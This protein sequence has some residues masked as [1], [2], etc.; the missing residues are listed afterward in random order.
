MSKINFVLGDALSYNELNRLQELANDENRKHLLFNKYIRKG[1]LPSSTGSP[2]GF[3]LYAGSDTTRFYVSRGVAIT[4]DDRLILLREDIAVDKPSQARHIYIRY[5]EETAEEGTV[6]VDRGDT[7]VATME[8]VGT[9]FT[10]LLRQSQPG[11]P[12][13]VLLFEGEKNVEGR[14]FR[15]GSV[16]SD[17]LAT[18]L[19][20]VVGRDDDIRLSLPE[21]GKTFRYKVLPFTGIG[22]QRANSLPFY[23][24]DSVEIVQESTHVTETN[25]FKIG[26][27][28]GGTIRDSRIWSTASE[29]G[30]YFPGATTENGDADDTEVIEET[31]TP[32]V[33]D[34]IKV[35]P[36]ADMSRLSVSFDW[37]IKVTNVDVAVRSS[38]KG[39]L[40]IMDGSVVSSKVGNSTAAALY[41]LLDGRSHLYKAYIEDEPVSLQI[42]SVDATNNRIN[43]S[44]LGG[45]ELGT[46]KDLRIVP[47]V[48]KVG[49]V[50]TRRASGANTAVA[51]RGEFN[52]YEFNRNSTDIE[53]H[54]ATTFDIE[55]YYVSK[56]VRSTSVVNWA[57]SHPFGVFNSSNE[58]V[59]SNVTDAVRFTLFSSSTSVSSSVTGISINGNSGNKYTMVLNNT[60]AFTETGK[61]LTMRSNTTS[62]DII[63]LVA[64]TTLI[65][66]VDLDLSISKTDNNLA[67]KSG[68]TNLGDVVDLS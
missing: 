23:V 5:K 10:K 29:G 45:I 21:A 61:G 15:V 58:R 11:V 4:E 3:Q 35:V 55:Y 6:T 51:Y 68:S 52:S 22:S 66:S 57:T 20:A 33:V 67:L 59:L 63:E 1:I 48:D 62:P 54:G 44:S 40:T 39:E 43:V 31:L 65:A 17:V 49:V 42:T 46:N 32:P 64:G 25:R 16:Q 24:Y 60:T 13:Y 53:A 14:R 27:I 50:I 9:E 19:G 38:N 8:G 47:D 18:L 12:V 34:E 36:S 26:Y 28:D 41:A 30:I 2:L 7:G 56:G 37:S